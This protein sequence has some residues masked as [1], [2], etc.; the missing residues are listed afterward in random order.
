[1]KTQVF[2]SLLFNFNG[3]AIKGRSLYHETK[4]SLTNWVWPIG[5]KHKK[6]YMMPSGLSYEGKHDCLAF[7]QKGGNSD[8]C[9][10]SFLNQLSC[11]H[12]LHAEKPSPKCITFIM[13][14]GLTL[15]RFWPLKD[16]KCEEQH[17]VIRRITVIYLGF[18]SPFRILHDTFAAA[19]S[20]YQHYW[21][22]M[23]AMVCFDE[24]CCGFRPFSGVS[25]CCLP[26]VRMDSQSGFVSSHLS[27]WFQ[28]DCMQE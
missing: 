1:M 4:I 9:F 11:D 25:V 14:M 26:V 20:P 3:D 15:E 17:N 22:P 5:Y 12:R 23:H 13:G 7:L 8:R 24:K 27:H 21:G 28:R 19:R 2:L 10:S 6:N 16:L 18:F